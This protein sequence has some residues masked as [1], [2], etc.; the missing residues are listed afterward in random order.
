MLASFISTSQQALLL[1]CSRCSSIR[2]MTIS[3][4]SCSVVCPSDEKRKF[5]LFHGNGGSSADSIVGRQLPSYKGE[6]KDEEEV[7]QPRRTKQQQQDIERQPTTTAESLLQPPT[8]AVNHY[9]HHNNVYYQ[10]GHRLQLTYD[11]VMED[12]SSFPLHVQRLH[13][14]AQAVRRQLQNV[15]LS[16]SPPSSSFCHSPVISTR[17]RR[18]I[19]HDQTALC[20]PTA[21]TSATRVVWAAT[22]TTPNSHKNALISVTRGTVLEHLTELLKSAVNHHEHNPYKWIYTHGF[23]DGLL[24]YPLEQLSTNDFASNSTR[25]LSFWKHLITAINGGEEVGC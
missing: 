3:A 23:Q 24:V 17:S 15:A 2:S 21:L 11:K 16:C 19:Y 13:Y 14:A 10:H 4:S 18:V 22:T 6:G 9:H 5:L 1:R 7:R 12:A 20:S 8:P 25:R